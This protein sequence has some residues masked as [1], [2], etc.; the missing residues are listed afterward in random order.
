MEKQTR[1]ACTFEIH[2]R[3]W[4][5]YAGR[6]LGLWDYKEGFWIDEHHQFAVVGNERYWVPP[7]A[8]KYVEKETVAV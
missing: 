2:G 1:Y 4:T 6:G 5:T 7:A 8:I 3:V